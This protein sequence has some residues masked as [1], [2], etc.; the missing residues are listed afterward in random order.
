MIKIHLFLSFFLSLSPPSF[1]PS[2]LPLLS[3][4]PFILKMLPIFKDYIY[5]TYHILF[6]LIYY[7]L[8]HITIILLRFNS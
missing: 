1:L 2:F 5:Y 8:L 4:Y 3:I 6:F 7:I